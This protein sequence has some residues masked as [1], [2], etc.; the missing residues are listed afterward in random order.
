[1]PQT[2]K[3]AIKGSA[4]IATEQLQGTVEYVEGNTLVVRMADGA[5]R[6]FNV[7]ESRRFLIDG[8][9]LTVHDL[10]AGNKTQ[11]D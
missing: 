10:K 6:E 2:T 8:R 5:I 3:E 1:M 9:E 11:R 7:P 4:S